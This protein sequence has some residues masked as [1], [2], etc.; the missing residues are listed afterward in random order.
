MDF[1][2]TYGTAPY[3]KKPVLPLFLLLL[4]SV[5]LFVAAAAKAK[6][7]EADRA[8]RKQHRAKDQHKAPDTYGLI[9]RTNWAKWKVWKQ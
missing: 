2:S 6:A 3:F 5:H 8:L 7:S 1:E 9:T 4:L